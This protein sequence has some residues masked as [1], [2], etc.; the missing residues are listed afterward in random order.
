MKLSSFIGLASAIALASAALATPSN[1]QSPTQQN[2]Q[3]TQSATQDAKVVGDLNEITQS[4]SQVNDQ[5]QTGQPGQPGGTQDNLQTAEQTAEVIGKLNL[6]QQKIDQVNSQLQKNPRD[7]NT[8][9]RN[10]NNRSGA[11]NQQNFQDARQNAI[12]VGELNQVKQEIAQVN[13]QLQKRQQRQQRRAENRGGA[14]NQGG[15]NT[16]DNY[17]NAQQDAVVVGKLNRVEQKLQQLNL[18]L[19]KTR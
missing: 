15:A 14:N 1:A 13:E 18:Q 6:V 9:P 7:A 12:V 19:Q 11:N 5:I 3:N 4:I 10:G 17:Q 8:Y 2:Q 16:Q